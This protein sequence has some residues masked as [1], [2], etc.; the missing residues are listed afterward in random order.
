MRRAGHQLVN[1]LRVSILP[2][3]WSGSSSGDVG[4]DMTRQH[5]GSCQPSSLETVQDRLRGR[6]KREAGTRA[7]N[8]MLSTCT[9]TVDASTWAMN[10]GR[11]SPMASPS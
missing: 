6:G 3:P 1:R 2:R 9:L 10:F 5:A 8:P 7:V 4:R 11:H